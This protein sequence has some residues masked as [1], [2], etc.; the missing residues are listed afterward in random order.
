MQTFFPGNGDRVMV[1]ENPNSI[2]VY[3]LCGIGVL[4]VGG[5]ISLAGYVTFFKRH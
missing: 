3:L 1:I 2:L 5:L 4:T